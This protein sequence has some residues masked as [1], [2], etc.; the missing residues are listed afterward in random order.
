[1]NC[2]SIYNKIVEYLLCN[3]VFIKDI[4]LELK[5]GKIDIQVEFTKEVGKFKFSLFIN[6][7][8]IYVKNPTGHLSGPFLENDL[9]RLN[10]YPL[11]TEKFAYNFSN[12]KLAKRLTYTSFIFLKNA[13]RKPFS[14]ETNMLLHDLI[15]KLKQEKVNT[16][17][18]GLW[19]KYTKTLNGILLQCYDNGGIYDTR[20]NGE[21][22]TLTPH[23]MGVYY[24]DAYSAY[25]FA[26]KFIETK[27][28][29]YLDAA[30]RA[31]E[32]IK[33]TYESYPKDIVWYH[34]DF[35]NPA[36]IETLPL[37]K[38]YIPKQKYMELFELVHFMRQDFYEPTNVYALRYH[39]RQAKEN[40]GFKET[41]EI[42]K[43]LKRLKKDQTHDGLIH[44][45]N[46][47]DYNDAHDLTYHQYS[48]ACIA[49]RLQYKYNKD[50]E[51]IFKKGCKFSYA[52]LTEN[53]EINYN[54]RGSNNIYSLASA[55]Y[56]F[57][58][59]AVLFRQPKFRFGAN[60]MLQYLSR[61]QQKE[62]YFPTAMNPYITKRMAW[63]HCH[64]PYN[65]L[66]C[67]LLY[68]SSDL[69]KRK[70]GN[71]LMKKSGLNVMND[72]GYAFFSNKN[73]SFAFFS[74]C[75]K[76]YPWSE[77][78]HQTGYAGTAILSI[79][80]RGNT[81]LLLDKELKHNVLVSD[82][83]TFIVNDNT[84][85]FSE[86]GLL[87]KIGIST[88]EYIKEQGVLK[89]KREFHL[90]EKCIKIKTIISANKNIKLS[91]DGLVVF[92]LSTNGG[93]HLS[94]KN[95]SVIQKKDKTQIVYDADKLCLSEIIEIDSNPIGRGKK[96]LFG[97]LENHI[98]NKDENLCYTHRI[99]LI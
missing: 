98:M 91:C 37:I 44:D 41:R 45:N 82:I 97:K 66:T 95:N 4:P 55:I 65:A 40:M 68:K 57:E 69:R 7:K 73:Y 32:F 38:E 15:R 28:E 76:S 94:I 92:P 60:K 90:E 58:T 78:C 8:G 59:A 52:I 56:A 70:I 24:A 11:Q 83:P 10:P 85:E 31:L 81:L 49:G 29:K 20:A 5:N 62:G 39:W 79:K 88:F 36:Y 51:E 33:R 22:R 74:G 46:L 53:G 14:Y 93:W 47:E 67:Y 23:V 16:D 89:L 43:C 50:A 48:L 27:E 17:E 25:C 42:K 63:N 9:F 87:T 2:F 86:R 99:E 64:T 12:I 26:R 72:A 80:D 61:W 13:I 21:G 30:L 3:Q 18:G 54:G 96:V 84:I 71:C 34:H 1:M 19:F 77:G 35:K 6:N 75:A